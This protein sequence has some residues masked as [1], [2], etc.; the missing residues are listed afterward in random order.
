MAGIV[1]M[2]VGAHQFNLLGQIHVER[3]AKLGFV[4]LVLMTG[5]L[6]LARWRGT[7]FAL[8]LLGSFVIASLV[9]IGPAPVLAALVLATLSASIALLLFGTD[10]ALPLPVRLLAG[11]SLTG[12]A[13]GWTL[14][15][16]IHFRAVYLLLAV[17]IILPR[18][19]GVLDMLS[20]AAGDLEASVRRRPG[21]ASLTLLALIATAVNAWP[22]SLAFDDLGYH[23]IL[24]NQLQEFGYYRMDA[25]S[26]VW[27]FA[28]WLGDCLFGFA[29]VVAGQDARGAVNLIWLG[30]G[31][32]VLFQLTR[33]LWPEDDRAA[34]ISVAL[35]FSLPINA[36]LMLGMQTEL[37]STTL[38]LA[39]TFTLLCKQ[40]EVVMRQRFLAMALLL[41]AL[42]LTKS[43]MLPFALLLML[44]FVW[45]YRRDLSLRDRFAL[46]ALVLLGGGS[47]Y[48]YAWSLTGNPVLPL[49]NAFFQSA[50]Y[51]VNDFSNVR[52][53]APLDFAHVW[54]LL[55]DSSSFYES[56]DGVGGFHWLPLLL[57]ALFACLRAPALRALALIAIVVAALI[58]SAQSYLRYLMP[59][60][61]LMMPAFAAG[62]CLLQRRVGIA[63]VVA[64][65]ASNFI[66]QTNASW[67]LGSSAVFKEF[68]GRDDR[69]FRDRV[70]PEWRLLEVAMTGGPDVRVLVVAQTRPFTAAAAG[71]AFTI[72][73][74]D[75]E[76]WQAY[77]RPQEGR[78]D[79][80]LR[81]YRFT[82]AVTHEDLVSQ[83]ELDDLA[84]LGAVAILRVEKG[85]LWQVPELSG[86][87]MDLFTVRDRSAIA[88]FAKLREQYRQWHRERK[89]RNPEKYRDDAP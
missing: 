35:Y 20:Q 31:A 4:V 70:A 60:F 1:L 75:T 9:V 89:I 62:A 28:P 80:L 38:L 84:R 88:G 65:V 59:A 13:L 16:P 48:I 3:V 34:W 39:A 29:Q 24:P 85:T 82:H 30:T 10:S 87:R 42:A 45:R 11:L 26:Q 58:F 86:E 22:P 23:L 51:P 5:G 21:F 66:F 37:F 44:W 61:A 63:L 25:A 57:P 33:L 67:I 47:A 73:W 46:P 69:Q 83:F 79:A 76:L 36:A 12:L 81:R 14:P 74:Y 27:A 15:L 77:K 32:T 17:A 8:G 2:L 53:N 6:A 55:F 49:A 18:I 54:G 71:R 41:G 50:Y 7:P 72:S 19:R 68:T 56:H 64:L 78:L 40:A 43:S 52:Y